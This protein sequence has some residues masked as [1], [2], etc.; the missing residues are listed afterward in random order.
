M[1]ILQTI[2]SLAPVEYAY[3]YAWIT[4]KIIC[5]YHNTSLKIEASEL[6]NRL[7]YSAGPIYA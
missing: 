7:K 4:L 6:K 2:A 3:G 5:V 1:E